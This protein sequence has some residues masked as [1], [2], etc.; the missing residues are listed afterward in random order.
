VTGHVYDESAR[1]YEVV[2]RGLGKDYRAE[3]DEIVALVARH[4]PGARTMLDVGCGN[5]DHLAWLA[6]AFEHVEGMELSRGMIDEAAR[7]HPHLGITQGDMRTFRL[8]RPFDVVT[9][10]FSAIGYMT[11]T[12]DLAAAVANMAAHLN[13]AG[14]LVAEAWL[15]PEQWRVEHVVA[16]AFH[17]NELA[18]A[19]VVRSGRAA[20]VSI[21]DMQY[22]V[23]S[24]SGIRHIVERHEMG[25]FTHLEYRAAVAAS[26]LDYAYEHGLTGRGLHLGIRGR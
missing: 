26:G 13:P 18:I 23:A 2:Q 25:L 24:A 14:L 22:L 15:A 10:L 19:R 7:R 11:T 12:D 1:A 20:N 21:L 16:D 4:A 5:G 3:A 6:H 9:C 17:E 8:D